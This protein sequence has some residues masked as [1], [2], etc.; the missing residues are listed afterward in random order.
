MR[1]IGARPLGL[2]RREVGFWLKLATFPVRVMR[3]LGAELL[4][5]SNAA[6]GLNPCFKNGDVMVIED[7]INLMNDN[8]LIGINDERL[9]PRFPDMSQPYD[10]DLVEWCKRYMLRDDCPLASPKDMTIPVCVDDG[11]AILRVIREHHAA[12]KAI[13]SHP[14]GLP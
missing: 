13:N 8:P 6:G 5:V 9:G 4:I 11:P 7:H 12:W 14:P 3:A 1:A 10:A 2:R